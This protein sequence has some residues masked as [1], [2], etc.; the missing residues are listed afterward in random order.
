[1][2]A[3]LFYLFLYFLPFQSHNTI[4]LW[5]MWIT[6][7]TIFTTWM[8]CQL[9]RHCS[10]QNSHPGRLS[11]FPNSGH[12]VTQ[13]WKFDFFLSLNSLV[14]MAGGHHV[15]NALLFY[16]GCISSSVALLLHAVVQTQAFVDSSLDC[17]Q[18][19][20]YLCSL[21]LTHGCQISV[22]LPHASDY[23]ISLGNNLP[24]TSK[25]TEYILYSFT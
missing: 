1:M 25:P 23:A 15:C 19:S 16:L 21:R 3:P 22:L 8:S 4:W 11:I 24:D 14:T 7:K 12:S 6:S 13:D 2:D 17:H 20:F 9:L 18:A 5:T 10:E